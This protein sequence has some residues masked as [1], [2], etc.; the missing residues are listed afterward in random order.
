MGGGSLVE[1]RE[2]SA[3]EESTGG[4]DVSV[5]GCCVEAVTQQHVA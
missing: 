2:G 4:T 1:A 5:R 3:C